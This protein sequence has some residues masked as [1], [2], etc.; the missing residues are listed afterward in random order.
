MERAD[1]PTLLLVIVIITPKT[2]Y[3]L[4]FVFKNIKTRSLSKNLIIIKVDVV[5]THFTCTRVHVRISISCMLFIQTVK[6]KNKKLLFFSSNCE[7]MT[8]TFRHGIVRMMALV[9]SCQNEKKIIKL[10]W[11]MFYTWLECLMEMDTCRKIWKTLYKVFMTISDEIKATPTS[12]F[13]FFGPLYELCFVSILHYEY[14]QNFLKLDQFVSIVCILFSVAFP[15][16][17]QKLMKNT[18]KVSL[19]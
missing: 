14:P 16:V 9:M 18:K 12:E 1:Q 5:C 17:F 6:K 3:S 13:T 8:K 15:Y 2:Y 4:G 19:F 11:I 7:D 10:T